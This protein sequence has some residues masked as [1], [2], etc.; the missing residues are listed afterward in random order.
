MISINKTLHKIKN[1]N[2]E[3]KMAVPVDNLFLKISVALP[4]GFVKIEIRL[5]SSTDVEVE[6]G[7]KDEGE[8]G[9][10]MGAVVLYVS[11]LLVRLNPPLILLP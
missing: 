5:F 9:I 2:F 11:S 8:G 3:K 10:R 4:I 7:V 1:E 6:V